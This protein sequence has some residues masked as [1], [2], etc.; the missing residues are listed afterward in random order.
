MLRNK[1]LSQLSHLTASRTRIILNEE[2]LA[3][4]GHIKA[5]KVWPRNLN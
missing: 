3:K 2:S 1:T 4:T 5:L